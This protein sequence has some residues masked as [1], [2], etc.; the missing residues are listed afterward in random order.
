LRHVCSAHKHYAF[1]CKKRG[2][3]KIANAQSKL[4]LDAAKTSAAILKELF[5]KEYCSFFG[6]YPDINIYFRG[7]S[8]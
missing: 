6:V 1:E 5:G 8:S 7:K 3:K 4:A 2:D